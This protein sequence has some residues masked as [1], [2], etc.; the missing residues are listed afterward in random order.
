M[1]TDQKKA[2]LFI[3]LARPDNKGISK[4]ID[5]TTLSDKYEELNVT[6]GSSYSRKSS[7]LQEDYYLIKIYENGRVDTKNDTGDNVGVGLGK[8]KTIQLNG[9]KNE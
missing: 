3:E 8:L 1:G 2:R 9:F 4:P 5:V 7:Q 6:N